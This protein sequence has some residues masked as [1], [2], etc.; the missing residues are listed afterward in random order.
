MNTN[1]FLQLQAALD[2]PRLQ[3]GK[4]TST[5]GDGTALVALNGAGSA[6]V[7]NPLGIAAGQAVFVRAGEITAATP[8]LPAVFIEI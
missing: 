3:T 5:F 8:D 6:R 1:L 2:A 4:V 7:R